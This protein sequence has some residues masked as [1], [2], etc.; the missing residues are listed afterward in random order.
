MKYRTQ[1]VRDHLREDTEDLTDEGRIKYKRGT[2][3]LVSQGLRLDDTV[4]DFYKN[5]LKNIPTE[6]RPDFIYMLIDSRFGVDQSYLWFVKPDRFEKQLQKKI[7]EKQEMKDMLRQ[8]SDEMD[9]GV[10]VEQIDK[11]LDDVAKRC[12]EDMKVN[13][14]IIKRRHAGVF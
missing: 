11:I 7:S 9:I 2:V 12:T 10:S 4:Y 6:K 5:I 8:F 13:I 3:E 1:K 14:E